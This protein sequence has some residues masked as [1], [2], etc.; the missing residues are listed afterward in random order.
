MTNINTAG[1][2]TVKLVGDVVAYSN[3]I[4]NIVLDNEDAYLQGNILNTTATNTK[5]MGTNN[6]TI[7]N[8]ASWLP[9]FDNR[10]GSFIVDGDTSTYSLSGIRKMII[11]T[12]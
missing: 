11:S 12:I 8:D 10:N 5:G 4:N 7:T 1:G 6:I 9:V 2:N 3:G